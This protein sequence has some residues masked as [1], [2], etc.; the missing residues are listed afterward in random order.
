MKDKIL[1]ALI[2]I[3]AAFV[4]AHFFEK[5]ILG[6]LGRM[7]DSI[8]RNYLEDVVLFLSKTASW[9]LALIRS[10]L[11]FVS[12]AILRIVRAATGLL[13]L[14]GRVFWLFREILG[15]FGRIL[16]FLRGILP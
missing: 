14:I 6:F 10:V 11:E 1:Q 4:V 2:L 9:A 13:E 8:F 7:G 15:L 12:G 3:L 16:E 5:E